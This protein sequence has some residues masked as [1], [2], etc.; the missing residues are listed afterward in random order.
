MNLSDKEE[1]LLIELKDLSNDRSWHV[2]DWPKYDWRL[3][4]GEEGFC[5]VVYFMRCRGMVSSEEF[6]TAE[7]AIRD[8][9]MEVQ[10][11]PKQVTA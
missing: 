1:D 11:R 2:V 9:I 5:T 10:T 7:D 3:K 4:D 6:P 8:A